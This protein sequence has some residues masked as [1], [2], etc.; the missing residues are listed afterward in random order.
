MWNKVS[1]ETG[2]KL[3]YEGLLKTWEELVFGKE[4]TGYI[5][6]GRETDHFVVRR[7]C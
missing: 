7:I 3:V 4:E 2:T 5:R 1:K 6:G